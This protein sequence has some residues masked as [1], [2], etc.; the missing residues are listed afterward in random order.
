[1]PLPSGLVVK[2]GSNTRS[3]TSGGMPLPVSVTASI[4]YWPGRDIVLDGHSGRRAGR[5]P[6]R[7]SGVP[8]PFMASRALIARLRMAFS[9]WL[10]STR[11]F[12]SPPE[13]TVSTSISSPSARRSMSSMP[14]MKRPTLTTFGSSGWRRPKARSWRGQLGAARDAR[15]R[16]LHPRLGPLVAGDVLRE[17]LQVAADHLQQVVEVVRDAAGQLAERLHLLRAAQVLLELLALGDVA[18]RGVE[19]VAF[20]DTEPAV[21]AVGAVLGPH[22]HIEVADDWHLPVSRSNCVVA[23]SRSSGWARASNRIPMS[24]AGS[25]PSAS[26]QAGLRLR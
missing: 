2:K 14:L 23:A 10:G 24:F 4:T 22:P 8:C 19:L 13:T 25:Y 21:P 7:S 12:H 18:A 6:P 5:C 16:V 17:Q 11:V 20:R 9:I 3:R 1:M 15:E 26:A